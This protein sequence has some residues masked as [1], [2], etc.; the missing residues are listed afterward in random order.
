ML[1]VVSRELS[2]ERSRSHAGQRVGTRAAIYLRVS[3]GERH[4]ENQR[5]DVER[6]ISTRGLELVTEYEEKASAVKARPVFERMLQEAHRGAF[7]VL[8]VWSLDR[9]GRSMVGNLRDVL[10]LDRR[11]V[12]VVSV[13]E[14]WLD[15]GSAV[16]PLLVAIFGWVAEQE[17]ATIVARTKAGLERARR[18]GKRLGRPPRAINVRRARAL[19]EEGLSLRQIAKRLRVPTMTLHGALRRTEN[20]SPR[21]AS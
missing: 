10:E 18:Q 5:P 14:T 2:E 20:G 9:F 16:R 8:V 21:V 4:T 7:D 11:G 3:K 15:T 12:Q 19:L 6:V 1:Q 17:R 13:R